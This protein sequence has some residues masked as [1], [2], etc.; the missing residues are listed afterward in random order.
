ME[1]IDLKKQ[2]AQIDKKLMVSIEKV[3]D[4]GSYILGPEITDLEKELSLFSSSKFC[5]TVASGTDAL[6]M[7]LM[8][9]DVRPGDEIITTPFTWISTV[10]VIK[11]LGAKPVYCD[12]DLATFNL[13]PDSI[14]KNITNKTKGIIPVSLFGQCADFDGINNIANEEGLFVI[15]DAAQ[16]FG[17]IYKSK[18]SCSLTTIGCTSFFPSKP[19]GCYGDGGACFTDNEL[20]YERL[21]AVR[22]HG[23]TSKNNFEYVGI[24]GRM[25]TLQAAILLLKLEIFEKEI[26]LRNQKADIYQELFDSYNNISHDVIVKPPYISEDTTSVYAQYTLL[27][28]NRD[29][30]LQRLK[31]NSIPYAIH[32]EKLAFE[33]KAF[34]T[35][36]TPKVPA[37]EYAK[38]RVFSIPMHPY[39]EFE[40]QKEIVDCI[41]NTKK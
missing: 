34:S 40:D 20:L 38:S 39:L 30:I 36:Y 18:R 32:Y 27:A 12:I 13:D 33:H 2:K 23:A 14:K 24:N 31:R 17:A 26:K 11:L 21:K 3:L 19:L 25:D 41:F 22:V 28:D 4:Q 8:A 1:F 16:S 5:L 7:S 29:E 15:E 10:E 35:D 37:A 6:L 9:L